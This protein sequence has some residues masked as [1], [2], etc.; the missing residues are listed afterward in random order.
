MSDTWFWIMLAAVILMFVLLAFSRVEAWW[1]WRRVHDLQAELRR[2][3]RE[4]EDAMREAHNLSEQIN[5]IMLAPVEQEQ[6]PK[7]L[8]GYP[9]IYEG[10]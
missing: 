6:P 5:A 3:A 10:G 8:P 2:A 9:R 1:L 7:P 4:Q